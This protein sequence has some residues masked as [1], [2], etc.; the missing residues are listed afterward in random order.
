ML[1]RGALGVVGPREDG[2]P[3][4]DDGVEIEAPG[5]Y[6][7]LSSGAGEGVSTTFVEPRL[8]MEP[9]PVGAEA[10]PVESLD[11]SP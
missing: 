3:E 10:T 6:S 2:D 5:R 8:N 1:R 11:S 7:S 4:D 9:A